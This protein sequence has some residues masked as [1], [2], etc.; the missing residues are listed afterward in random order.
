MFA[1]AILSFFL[2]VV[3]VVVL[4]LESRSRSVPQADLELRGSSDPPTSASQ[5]ARITGVC[6]HTQLMFILFGRDR[7][8]LCWPGWA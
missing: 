5:V 8:S 6:H 7:V 2:L 1:T 4:N 3:V